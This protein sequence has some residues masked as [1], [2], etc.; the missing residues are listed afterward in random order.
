MGIGIR[1]KFCRF[2]K[3]TLCFGGFRSAATRLVRLNAI[4]TREQLKGKKPEIEKQK[5]KQKQNKTKTKTHLY[6]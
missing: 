2:R 4:C 5:Q 1:P 3:L 6:M